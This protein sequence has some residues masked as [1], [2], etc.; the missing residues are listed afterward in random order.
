MPVILP[1]IIEAHKARIADVLKAESL[2]PINHTKIYDKYSSLTTK[3]AE[4][5]VDAFLKEEHSFNEYEKEVKRYQKLVKEIT[6]N[7]QKVA[8]VGMFELHC[9]ELI[10]SLAKRASSLLNK[11]IERMLNEHFET[12]KK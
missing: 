12:N 8:R 2:G 10:A 4:D 7:S 3:K 5:D 6:Y 9:D 11:L 1:N